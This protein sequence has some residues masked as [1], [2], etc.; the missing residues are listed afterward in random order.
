MSRISVL[1]TAEKRAKE[2]ANSRRSWNFE[3]IMDITLND[4]VYRRWTPLSEASV[5]HS[6]NNNIKDG[7][8]AAARKYV[9]SAAP[10]Q[11]GWG[12]PPSSQVY[13]SPTEITLC[14]GLHF[15]LW[16]RDSGIWWKK[17]RRL[18]R[19]EPRQQAQLRALSNEQENR[20]GWR[21]WPNEGKKP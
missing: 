16:K 4:L 3:K 14:R 15:W 21:S 1:N 12:E 10:G 5:N 6:F 13:E 19:R 20:H 7:V 2:V 9:C 11:K 18:V 17:L 8:E